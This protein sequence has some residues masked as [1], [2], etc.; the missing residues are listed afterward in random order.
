MPVAVNTRDGRPS[1]QQ[2]HVLGLLQEL[3]V[4]ANLQISRIDPKAEVAAYSAE[5]MASAGANLDEHGRATALRLGSE[6]DM[7]MPDIPG[8]R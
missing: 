4:L 6:I 1:D 7:G 3:G 5:V 2:S 8:L